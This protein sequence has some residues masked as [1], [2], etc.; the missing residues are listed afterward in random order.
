MLSSGPC[1]AVSPHPGQHHT[2]ELQA[3]A[4]G[5]CTRL[6]Y[7]GEGEISICTIQC[8][9][10]VS[11]NTIQVNGCIVECLGL[12]SRHPQNCLSSYLCIKP[13]IDWNSTVPT[14]NWPHLCKLV[15][16]T[17]W[18]CYQIL[19]MQSQ[20]GVLLYLCCT[21]HWDMCYDTLGS[22]HYFYSTAY[23]SDFMRIILKHSWIPWKPLALSR[24]CNNFIL[25]C[26]A[27]HTCCSVYQ[28]FVSI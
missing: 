18:Y 14:V 1:W 20:H 8:L 19:R 2:P 6:W 7:P 4:L 16:F 10:K 28:I 3:S 17:I 11:K 15:I 23:G 22:S 24:F 9:L 25:L 12:K 5:F 21:I 13:S 26:S 27:F